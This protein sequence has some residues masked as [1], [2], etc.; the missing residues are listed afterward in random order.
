M[1]VHQGSERL[2]KFPKRTRNNWE[3]GNIEGQIRGV[4]TKENNNLATPSGKMKIK[5]IFYIFISIS[6]SKKTPSP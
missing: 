1:I 4:K 2:N 6:Y 5:K 3:Y